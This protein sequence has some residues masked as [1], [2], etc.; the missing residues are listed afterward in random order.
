MNPIDSQKTA[1]MA[2]SFGTNVRVSSWIEV[3]AWNNPTVRPASRA[4]VRMGS[5]MMVAT[6]SPCRIVSKKTTSL[7]MGQTGIRR[8]SW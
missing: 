6:Q 7:C 1:T 5:D 3:S 2:A 8:I 4:T